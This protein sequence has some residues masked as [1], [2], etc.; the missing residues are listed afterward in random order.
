MKIF[1]SVLSLLILTC[2]S[3]ESQAQACCFEEPTNYYAEILGGPNFLQT[4]TNGGIKSNYQTGYIIAGSLGYRWC[5]GMRLEGEY[6]FRRNNLKSIHFFGRTFSTRGHFQ[7]SSYMANLLWDI[8]VMRWGCYFWNLQPLI[9]VGI[10]YDCQQVKWHNEGLIFNSNKKHFAW[11]AIAGL[12][13]PV[14]CNT[15]ISL[16]YKFHKGGFS[17][18]NNHSLGIGLRY[19]FSL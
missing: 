15:M 10:G 13:Y 11:Q 19:Q 17:Y 4:E 8:P 18:I 2:I 9:G 14:M 7:S 16:V 1:F 3:V 6:A 5:Y 12:S